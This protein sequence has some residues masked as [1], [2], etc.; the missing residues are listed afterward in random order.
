MVEQA[1]T[2][3]QFRIINPQ[4]FYTIEGVKLPNGSYGAVQVTKKLLDGGRSYIQRSLPMHITKTG[5]GPGSGPLITAVLTA[6]FDNKGVEGVEEL[7]ALFAGDFKEWNMTSTGITYRAIHDLVTH[8]IGLPEQTTLEA[9]LV[10]PDGYVDKKMSQVMQA[11][12]GNNDADKINTVYKWVTG[13]DAYLWRLNERPTKDENRVLLLGGGGSGI[14]AGAN[15]LLDL[16]ARGM[17]VAPQI[18]TENRS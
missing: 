7:K 9:R 16:P 12:L 14:C 10:G 17:R 1:L 18:S 6:L 3:A 15:D 5:W 4:D 8:D 2:G 11:L 13:G